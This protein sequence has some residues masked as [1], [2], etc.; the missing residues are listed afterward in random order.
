MKHDN[1]KR[2]VLLMEDIKKAKEI[3]AVF[4]RM[5]IISEFYDS[6]RTFWKDILI[7]RPSLCVVDVK[8]MSDGELV[9]KN[10]PHVRSKKLQVLFYYQKESQ[11]LLFSTF[12]LEFHGYI[13][14]DVSIE[15]Q[16]KTILKRVNLFNELQYNN[17]HTAAKHREAEKTIDRLTDMIDNYKVDHLYRD[18]FIEVRRLIDGARVH[19]DFFMACTNIFDNWGDVVNYAFMELSLNGQKLISPNGLSK[20]YTKLPSLFPG[21]TCSD[22]IELFAQNLANQ[23]SLDTMGGNLIPIF[24]K[25]TG[26]LPEKILFLQVKDEEMLSHFHWGELER[27]LTALYHYFIL[28]NK[29]LTSP[30]DQEN[31]LGSWDLLSLLDDYDLETPLPENKT[32]VIDINFSKVIGAIREREKGKFFWGKFYND[33]FSKLENVTKISFKLSPLSVSHTAVLVDAKELDKAFDAISDFAES[34][35][36]W[37]Y[38]EDPDLVLAED[39][40]PR[41]KMLPFSSKILFDYLSKPALEKDNLTTTWLASNPPSQSL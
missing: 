33:F 26:E 22:G 9:Y 15:G 23:V 20:K 1:N 31:T 4:R 36:C 5:E 32:A 28:R 13:N 37:R 39:L 24:V 21:K 30:K 10:H 41:L 19:G 35:P 12:E 8:L 25:G 2:I 7:S 27:Y 11:P 18:K 16:V 14:G 6:L 17:E 29:K 3:S 38:F 40:A 34:F